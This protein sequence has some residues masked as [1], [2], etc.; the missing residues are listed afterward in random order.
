MSGLTISAI[1][2]A[3]KAQLN[4]NVDGRQ[5]NVSEFGRT[6]P[7]PCVTIRYAS[8]DTIDYWETGTAAGLSKVRFELFIEPGT[9]GDE[10]SAVIR[11]DDFLSAGTGNNSSIIDAVM[12]DTTLGGVVQTC[13]IASAVVDNETVTATLGLEIVVKNVGRNA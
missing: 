8:G 7:A 12:A 1:R 13:H 2:A 5:I 11:L 10:D 4:V 9:G 6:L 3:I